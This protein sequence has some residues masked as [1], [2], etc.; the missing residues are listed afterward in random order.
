MKTGAMGMK[1]IVAR[2]GPAMLIL[3]GC[4]S[5]QAQ[6]PPPTGVQSTTVPLGRPHGVAYDSAGN[7][8]IADTDNNAIRKVSTAGIITTVAGTGAQGYAGDGGLAT[9]ALLDSPAGVA[10]DSSFNIYI[11]DTHNNVIREV[12]K[13]SGNI[14]TIAGTGAPG[15]S[16]DGAAATSAMLAYPTAVA[17]D[18]NTN[19]YIAD[20]NNHR[21]REITGTT[22]NTVAGNGQQ[23]YAGDGGLA[24]AA[25]LDS[26]N[27]VAVDSSFNIYIGDTHNQ[28]VRMVTN[29][30]GNISTLAG[31]GVKGFNSDGPGATAELA[32]PRGVA[33]DQSGNVYL[34]D[35]D[36]NL[37]RTISSGNV[38]TI[39]GS[40]VEGFF[41]DGAAATS[42]WLDT[43]G[44]V[45]ISGRTVLFSDTE[46]DRVRNLQGGMIETVAGLANPPTPAVLIS[47]TAGSGLGSSATFNWTAG[48]GVTAYW[49]NL[50]YGSS[51]VESKDIYNSGEIHT[52][53]LTVNS[54]GAYGQTVYATLNSLINGVW[55]SEVYSFT[56]SGSPVPA[57]LTEPSP[58]GSTLAGTTTNFTWNTG[59]GVPAYWLY[60]GT[61]TTLATS[62]NLYDSGQT[63][64]TS[65][66]V[67]GIPAY[68]QPIYVT[69]F[70]Q[71]NGVWQ[72]ASYTFAESG[73]PVAATLT[74]P[75]SGTQVNGSATFVW[76][77]GGAVQYYWLDVGDGPS[78]AAAKD[79]FNSGS[80]TE[81]TATVSGLPTYGG[82][83]YV[84]LYSYIS[85]A[86]QP[87]VYTFLETGTPQ[88]ATLTFPGTGATLDSTSQAFNW[89]AG[90]G[91]TYYWLNLGYGS[92]GAAAK[93]LYSSGQTTA[94]T[95]TVTG[96]PAYGVPIYATLYSYINGVWQPTVYTF[97]SS[98]APVAATMISPTSPSTLP[99]PSATFTWTAG[100]GVT[101]YWLNLG[102]SPTGVNSKNIYDSESTANTSATVTGLP[103]NGETV[104]ATLYSLIN[105]VWQ[106]V[107]YTY[108]AF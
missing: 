51:G 80:T 100:G 95:A 91:V 88:P 101:A 8:Y 92:S 71:I 77:P 36:N 82:T 83:L 98:G 18:S 54:L 17:L 39:A 31:T 13:S 33:V 56:E 24:T 29:S 40:G 19:I 107:Q 10:V 62:R 75:A 23:F 106:S 3:A 105:G 90:Q 65:A 53:S 34:A 102:T 26:P 81:T 76:S 72:P 61:G 103:S 44:A 38:T 66:N 28:R 6:N 97:T 108:T 46:N 21:I 67:T 25:G 52:T 99:S 45:A 86:W 93:N 70:S 74:L 15:Y 14:V 43:P 12:V 4:F 68:G 37:V 50:G 47:P 96:L 94:L 69:L 87:T 84:T 20:T 78:G 5:G 11:A 73:A 64:A 32:R 104:Y 89:T 59:G 79:L 16:G 27:G 30:T 35:S 60:V 22:I 85:G 57:A 9:L 7:Y 58:N 48:I 49:F 1:W 41:G 55:Q 2:V 42:A 63:V